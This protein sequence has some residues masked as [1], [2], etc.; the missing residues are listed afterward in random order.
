MT[1][2]Y[3]DVYFRAIASSATRSRLLR[4]IRYG[5]FL[6]MF[7]QT[8]EGD[9]ERMHQTGIFRQKLYVILFIDISIWAEFSTLVAQIVLGSNPGRGGSLCATGI[10][11]RPPSRLGKDD[12]EQQL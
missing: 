3:G 2:L 9:G 11:T 6:G 10:R 8:G 1:S 12:A 5:L 4:R 7:F